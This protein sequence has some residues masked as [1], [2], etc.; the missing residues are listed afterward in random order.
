MDKSQRPGLLGRI[1]QFLKDATV[2]A[3]STH[4]GVAGGIGGRKE[5]KKKRDG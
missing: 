2:S 5:R 4:G 1:K 3:T